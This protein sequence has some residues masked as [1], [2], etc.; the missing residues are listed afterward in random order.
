VDSLSPVREDLA[1]LIEQDLRQYRAEFSAA[2]SPPPHLGG[3]FP[4]DEVA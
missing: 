4:R 1:N 3:R 2:F